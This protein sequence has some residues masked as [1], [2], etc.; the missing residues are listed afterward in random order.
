MLHRL[1]DLD[2]SKVQAIENFIVNSTLPILRST[3][4]DTVPWGAGTVFQIDARLFVV[5]ARHVIDD[6]GGPQDIAFPTKGRKDLHPFGK[7]STLLRQQDGVDVAVLEILDSEIK[8]LLRGSWNALT[9]PNVWSES[10]RDDVGILGGYP[11]ELHHRRGDMIYQ[12]AL[13]VTADRLRTVPR[14]QSLFPDYDQFFLYGQEGELPDGST[15]QL[16]RL[17]GASGSSI[18]AFDSEADRQ[19]N[20]GSLWTAEGTV[21]IIGVQV[22][23]SLEKKWFRGASWVAVH[24]L[25]ESAQIRF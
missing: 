15:G 25:F 8:A 2:K 4:A 18:G 14:V 7:V 19:L 10:P 17:R 12:S 24:E 22:S 1:S 11:V 5:T 3:G 13:V 21:K 9:P 20:H 6:A 23:S 16:P